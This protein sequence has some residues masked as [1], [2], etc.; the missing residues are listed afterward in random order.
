MSN[1]MV[2]DVLAI[3]NVTILFLIYPHLLLVKI[4][5]VCDKA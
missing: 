4:N 2:T 1:L 5:N 3:F